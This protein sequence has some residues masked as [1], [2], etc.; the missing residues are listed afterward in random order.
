M[1]CAMMLGRP[2]MKR[3]KW[4]ATSRMMMSYSPPGPTP[5]TMVMVLPR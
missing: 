1:F 2:G 5:V 3:P 4:R